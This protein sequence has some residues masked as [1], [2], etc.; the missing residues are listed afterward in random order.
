M[1]SGFP[2]PPPPPQQQGS[3]SSSR[4]ESPKLDPIAKTILKKEGINTD[5]F[6]N[7]D[8]LVVLFLR[9]HDVDA[10]PPAGTKTGDAIS[11]AFFGAVG[12]A[13]SFAGSHLRQ[14]EKIA[15]MQ[16]W[17]SWKQWALGHADWPA[18]KEK[19][20]QDY[21]NNQ[22]VIDE[23]VN[24]PGFQAE[25][26]QHKI[27]QRKEQDKLNRNGIVA[28]LIAPV[29]LAV[30][31]IIHSYLEKLNDQR[32]VPALDYTNPDFYNKQ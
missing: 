26:E 15:A 13:A 4:T 29:A 5:P 31:G 10:R 14:Q 3:A 28:A 11:G 21:D 7:P 18:F 6:P 23:A 22:K 20:K 1:T 24:R 12:P 30:Y 2:S 17:T 9:E 32:S 19:V 16:E 8:Q 25:C 27:T